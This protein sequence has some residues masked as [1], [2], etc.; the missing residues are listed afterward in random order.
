MDQFR[1]QLRAKAYATR[2][3]VLQNLAT[4][5]PSTEAR[6]EISRHARAKGT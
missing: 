4:L 2:P 1:T 5:A 3:E 6:A